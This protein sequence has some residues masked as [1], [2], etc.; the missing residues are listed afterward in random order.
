MR[1]IILLNSLI[2]SKNHVV[3]IDSFCEKTEKLGIYVPKTGKAIPD[4]V[5]QVKNVT[6]IDEMDNKDH[7]I[8]LSLDLAGKGLQVSGLEGMMIDK[9][10]I[11][12]MKKL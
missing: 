3:T 10:T 2:D 8:T 1:Y 4:G 9:E 5:Y 11:D 7:K 12:S 6:V